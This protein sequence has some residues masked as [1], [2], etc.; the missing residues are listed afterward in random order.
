M[1]EAYSA[2]QVTVDGQK[3]ERD[4]GMD[5]ISFVKRAGIKNNDWCVSRNR[6]QAVSNSEKGHSR[7]ETNKGGAR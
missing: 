3:H 5:P 6:H 1:I 2:G 7:M 4:L